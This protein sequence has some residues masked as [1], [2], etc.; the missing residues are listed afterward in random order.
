MRHVCFV[1]Y[2]LWSQIWQISIVYAFLLRF[3]GFD[4]ALL[5]ATFLLKFGGW[6][7]KKILRDRIDCLKRLRKEHKNILLNNIFFK[8]FWIKAARISNEA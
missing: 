1:Q 4:Y 7:H 2:A 8:S 6:R 5:G 3:F